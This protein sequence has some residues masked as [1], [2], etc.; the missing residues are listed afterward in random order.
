MTHT[1]KTAKIIRRWY[2]SE[3]H[4]HFGDVMLLPAPIR[5]T[6][7]DLECGIQFKVHAWRTYAV[8]FG[9]GHA[10]LNE[11]GPWFVRIFAGVYC[12]GA[13]N[14]SWAAELGYY[15]RYEHVYSPNQATRQKDNRLYTQGKVKNT[16]A[17][18]LCSIISHVSWDVWPFVICI[19]MKALN[20]FLIIQR[21]V[22]LKRI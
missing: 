15:S 7:N 4:W 19:I 1:S 9:A 17:R 21:Q 18:Q 20:R 14:R 2:Y 16:T 22:T 3:A 8:A 5:M 6:L 12:G 11:H 13:T 10:W